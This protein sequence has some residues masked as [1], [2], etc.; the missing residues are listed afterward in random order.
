MTGQRKSGWVKRS[1]PRTT[2][3]VAMAGLLIAGLS[4]CGGGG[5]GDSSDDVDLRAAY[6]RI[7]RDCMTY[8]DVEKTVGR[9][10]DN[11]PHSETSHW[12]AGNERV[13]VYFVP[14]GSGKYVISSAFWRKTPGSELEKQF[15]IECD[16]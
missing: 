13:T 9:P 5:G 11:S 16:A 10:A 2:V 12:V 4:A 6:D 14:L 3:K 1:S 7:N 8:A 15:R